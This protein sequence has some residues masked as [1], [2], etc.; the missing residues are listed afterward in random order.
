MCSPLGCALRH[1]LTFIPCKFPVS[2]TILGFHKN[3]LLVLSSQPLLIFRVV[4]PY[5]L[6]A[7]RLCCFSW[8]VQ[9][10]P[11]LP[12]KMSTS[13]FPAWWKIFLDK[14]QEAY[15]VK[16]PWKYLDSN[17]TAPI[18]QADLNSKHWLHPLL[19]IIFWEYLDIL[20][21]F[22]SFATSSQRPSCIVKP[23]CDLLSADPPF[24]FPKK[25]TFT[26]RTYFPH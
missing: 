3:P 16:K 26:L 15:V 5:M 17:L 18:R 20:L 4:T 2:P 22:L 9:L 23:A 12:A 8:N 24:D 21:F 7:K 6:A 10:C 14:C 11:P 1:R 19:Q 13:P 25:F